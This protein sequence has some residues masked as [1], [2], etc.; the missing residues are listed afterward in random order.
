MA[1]TFSEEQQ[2]K[3]NELVGEA[4]IK[5]RNKAQSDFDA[6]TSKAQEEAARAAL[7]DG[8]QWQKLATEHESRVK[9]LEP[10]EAKVAAYDKVFTDMLTKRVKSMGD[11]AKKAIDAL[12]KSMGDLEKLEWLQTNEALFQEKGGPIGTPNRKHKQVEG[13]PSRGRQRRK[14]KL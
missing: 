12:P 5:E 14:Q 11:A 9:A 7:V 10:L 6:Q 13:D 4:R 1:V 3:V 8:E 2:E